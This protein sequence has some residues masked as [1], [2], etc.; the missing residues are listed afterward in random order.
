AGADLAAIKP[1]NADGADSAEADPDVGRLIAAFKAALGDAV[2]DVRRSDRLTESPV[3]L[4][5]DEHGLNL[6]LERL[7]KQHG[8]IDQL[9]KRV[10]EINPRHAIVTRLNALVDD[11]TR[12]QD[13]A[14]A[15]HLLLDQARILEGETV[16]DPAAFAQRL[17]RFVSRGLAA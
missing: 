6:H 5:A 15:A 13:I 10:L 3:C 9:S 7:L 1:A 11:S 12:A 17:N 16:P 8:Q 14:E 2:A 4:V